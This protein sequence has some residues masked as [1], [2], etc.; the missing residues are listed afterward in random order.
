MAH[1]N[2]TPEVVLRKILNEV[3][4]AENDDIEDIFSSF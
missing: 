2:V 1:V 4:D 3:S